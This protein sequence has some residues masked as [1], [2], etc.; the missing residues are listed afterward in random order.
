MATN[1]LVE[2]DLAR[3]AALVSVLERAGIPVEFV[4]W[5]YSDDD[6]EWRLVIATPLVESAGKAQSYKRIREVVADDP[7]LDLGVGRIVLVSPDEPGVRR[8]S[9]IAA[10]DATGELAVHGE[11][12][13]I[14]GRTVDNS[15]VYNTDALRYEESVLAALQRLAPSL[16]IRRAAT[17]L[18]H[19]REVDFVLDD[20]RGMVLV[21]AKA[22]KKRLG[23]AEL[24]SLRSAFPVNVPLVVVSRSGFSKDGKS[25]DSPTLALATWRTR[26]DDAELKTAIERALEARAA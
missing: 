13:V 1:P 20:G 23:Q 2:H 6:L 26:E 3:G 8:L 11:R 18:D 17:V 16:I 22:T 21:Q 7:S 24:R 25:F 15:Y 5:S 10:S 14:Q 9:D 12:G 19:G 4:A